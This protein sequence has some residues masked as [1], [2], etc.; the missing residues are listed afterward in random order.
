MTTEKQKMNLLDSLE[1]K[2]EGIPEDSIWRNLDPFIDQLIR[3]GFA[4]WVPTGDHDNLV[5][6]DTYDRKKI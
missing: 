6:T 3:R 4:K 2:K 1:E 5:L